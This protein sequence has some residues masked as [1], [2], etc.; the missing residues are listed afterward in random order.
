M[1]LEDARGAG[2]IKVFEQNAVLSTKCKAPLVVMHNSTTIFRRNIIVRV[3]APLPVSVSLEILKDWH[4]DFI[5]ETKELLKV[6][7]NETSVIVRMGFIAPE[8]LHGF[9]PGVASGPNPIA[10]RVNFILAIGFVVKVHIKPM[11]A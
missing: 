11:I 1:H 7:K 2:D 8:C 4:I 6:L 10:I 3:N 9:S 5:A